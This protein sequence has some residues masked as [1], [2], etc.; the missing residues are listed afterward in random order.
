MHA[1][2]SASVT[3]G[4]AASSV[5]VEPISAK[6]EVRHHSSVETRVTMPRKRLISAESVGVALAI[7]WTLASGGRSAT[8]ETETFWFSCVEFRRPSG[9]LTCVAEW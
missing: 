4:Q 8:A 9:F 1:F 6:S 7:D 2:C 5:S 3:A